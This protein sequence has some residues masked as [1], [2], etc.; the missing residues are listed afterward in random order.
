MEIIKLLS[1]KKFHVCINLSLIDTFAALQ[2][3][4]ISDVW[5][6]QGV[7]ERNEHQKLSALFYLKM[8]E[9]KPWVVTVAKMKNRKLIFKCEQIKVIRNFSAVSSQFVHIGYSIPI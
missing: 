2:G 9:I 3:D 1:I 6:V 8:G 5:L 4:A 7:I